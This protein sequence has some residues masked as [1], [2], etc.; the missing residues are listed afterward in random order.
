MSPAPRRAFRSGLLANGASQFSQIVIQLAQLPLLRHWFGEDS[1]SIWNQMIAI[2]M[3]LSLQ[4]LNVQQSV[5]NEMLM[6]EGRGER[7]RTVSLYNSGWNLLWLV[8]VP[9]LLVLLGAVQVVPW[10]AFVQSDLVAARDLTI[11]ASGLVLA[12]FFAQHT[13]M[14]DAGYRAGDKYAY[15][16]IVITFL[17][18]VEVACGL[19]MAHF[20]QSVA[21]YG[22]GYA[23]GKLFSLVFTYFNLRAV[24]P[25]IPKAPSFQF[26]ELPWPLLKEGL[27]Y[28]AAVGSQVIANDGTKSTITQAMSSATIA[29]NYSSM[30][31]LARFASQIS[32]AFSNI[33]WVE[34]ARMLGRGE[35]KESR[36]LHR[37]ASRISFWIT[38]LVTG[39]MALAAPTVY[40][41][42]LQ[43][44]KLQFQ[45]VVYAFIAG[46][47]VLNSIW[48]VSYI[49][50]MSINKG[51]RMGTIVFTFQ[52][53]MLVAVFLASRQW[54]LEGAAA[55]WF[56]NELVLCLY[57]TSRAFRVID[58][59]P[60]EFWRALL[61]PRAFWASVK[62]IKDRRS[63]GASAADDVP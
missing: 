2:N 25:W 52:A 15:G 59:S 58:E 8:T 41:L 37:K 53:F 24:V 20:T 48:S 4:A 10:Q 12:A 62:N 30:R 34:L 49:V 42:W 17:N 19:A 35:I 39:A 55:A 7:E 33:L 61:S 3:V 31:T 57:V 44:E 11:M 6:A 43:G 9:W 16:L 38:L 46:S 40:R 54:G 47:I 13:G 32:R 51:S 23:L 21:M 27:G 28:S 29:T 14:M 26:R 56:F 50:P 63:P 60:L 1:M 36:L 5:G 18:I 45:P 22:V